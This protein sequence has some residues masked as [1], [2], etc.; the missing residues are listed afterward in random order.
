MNKKKLLSLIQ[1]RE[2]TKL[3]FKLKI[4]ISSESGK[5]ELA[6]DVC[7][8]ANSKGGRGY[9]II[10][11][12]DRTKRLVGINKA[13]AL[14]E[15]KI[16]QVVSS[17]CEPPIPIKVEIVN[18]DGVDI[19]IITIFDGGQK[20][21]QIK[22]TGAF[23]IRRGSITDTMRKSELVAA[24]EENQLLT[25]ETCQI[26]NS[27]AEFLNRNLIDQY[28][29]SKG[30]TI[31]RENQ[32][33]LLESAGITYLDKRSR[34]VRCT[35]GG[36][37]VFCDSNNI[38]IPNNAI[39]IINKIND[40]YP[41]AFMINGTLLDMIDKTEEKMYTL[42]PRDYPV[43]AIMEAVKNSVMYREYSIIDKIIEI[44][45]TKNSVII[46]SPGQLVSKGNI[47]GDM[48]YNKRNMWIYDKLISLD[49]GKRFIN[50]GNGLVRIKEAFKGKRKVRLINSTLDNCFKVILPIN[51]E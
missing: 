7:A 3:D 45:L 20:P 21:Y 39:R 14:D 25:V 16:Q 35:F 8:I 17:R 44:V 1:Q 37:L 10:G 29:K 32:K 31:T 50:D 23:H 9:L 34:K 15:E 4:D 47:L 33:F 24:F 48:G 30:I 38:C 51:L 46:I 41:R 40:N 11:V 27:S 28:F 2:G 36:L 12:E 22:E 6:K 5:K 42:L 26:V 18:L 19:G 13:K 49:E 43:F